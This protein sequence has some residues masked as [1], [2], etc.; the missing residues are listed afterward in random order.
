MKKITFLLLLLIFIIFT[1]N[2]QSKLGVYGGKNHDVFLGCIN[3]SDQESESV[4]NIYSDY[5]STHSAKSIWNEI[6]IYGSKKSKYSP[7]NINAKYPPLIID[8]K[9]KSYGYLTVDKKNPNRT[10]EPI[11][12]LISENRDQIVKDLPGYYNFML[13]RQLKNQ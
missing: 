6:G 13:R 9:G 10:L 4:W 5:G 12:Q 11:G 1:V 3:C 7:F 2:A 8:K